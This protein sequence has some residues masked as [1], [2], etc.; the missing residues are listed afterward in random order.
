MTFGRRPREFPTESGLSFLVCYLEENLN[1]KISIQYS[2]MSFDTI[3][4]ALRRV[5][6]ELM[7]EHRK[8]F[9]Y[10]IFTNHYKCEYPYEVKMY[11]TPRYFKYLHQ[12]IVPYI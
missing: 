2:R 11:K 6:F 5:D 8:D 4:D 3:D 10:Y 7:D 12:M 1:K 9:Y